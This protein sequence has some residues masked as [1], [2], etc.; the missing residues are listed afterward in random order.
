MNM[1]LMKN[2]FYRRPGYYTYE[3]MQK[4]KIVV[5]TMSTMLRKI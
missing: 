3:V 4:S 1:F 5:G 2:I